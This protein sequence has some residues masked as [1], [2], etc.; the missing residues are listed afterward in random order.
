[1]LLYNAHGLVP[2][3]VQVT[4]NSPYS[5]AALVFAAP[6]RYT[7]EPTL[8]LLECTRNLGAHPDAFRGE[9]L[10][11]LCVFELH[12]RLHELHGSAVW[13]LPLGKALDASAEQVRRRRR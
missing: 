3:L 7:R 11:G 2:N 4:E 9:P 8:F 1:M 5:N 13:H 6:S 10:V 12:A